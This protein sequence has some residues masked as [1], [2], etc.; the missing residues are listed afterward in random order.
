MNLFDIVSD[1]SH[2]K[3]NY[4]KNGNRDEA[5]SA[6][7]PFMINKAFSMHIDTVMY[8]AEMNGLWQLDK[9]MQHDYFFHALPRKK[10]FGWIKGD[11]KDVTIELVAKVYQ[12]NLRRARDIL[13]LLT[14]DQ[15]SDIQERSKFIN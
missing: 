13:S 9:D 6:Y 11:A 5:L 1:L 7:N 4:L 10:R 2:E 15:I 14:P 3:N 8:A 12:V